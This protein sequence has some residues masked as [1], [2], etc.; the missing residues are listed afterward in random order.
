MSDDG[1]RRRPRAGRYR[2]R[3]GPAAARLRDYFEETT[4]WLGEELHEHPNLEVLRWNFVERI[5]QLQRSY[6]A[7]Q[8]QDQEWRD[9]LDDLDAGAFA[10]GE[11]R[12]QREYGETGWDGNPGY[13]PTVEEALDLELLMQ[14]RIDAI[15]RLRQ[16][17]AVVVRNLPPVAA[18][19][20]N[21]PV[22]QEVPPGPPLNEGQQ[23]P[24]DGGNQDEIGALF[25]AGQDAVV[26]G[27]NP[28]APPVLV[29]AGMVPAPA[30][31]RNLRLP[32]TK[33]PEFDGSDPEEF[34]TFLDIF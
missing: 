24:V 34:Q 31:P 5:A 3:I 23:Q 19:P 28:Q 16:A 32:E 22:R 33:I 12:D 27:E 20:D 11:D 7:I 1:R 25:P 14:L 26:H 10:D 9:Y 18:P 6:R 17:P 30:P 4:N 15:D 2:Q 13:I 8:A 21:P 29:P